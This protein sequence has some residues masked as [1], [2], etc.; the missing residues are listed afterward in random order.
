MV[1]LH[2]AALVQVIA[3]A[4][5]LISGTVRS[6][7]T[8]QALGFSIVTLLPQG[9]RQFTDSA[10]A[11][12]FEGSTSGTYILSVRQIGYAPLDTQIVVAGDS[13]TIVRVALRRL[14]IELPPVTVTAARCT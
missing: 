5:P 3:S 9:V 14:A 7:E 12:A 2:T 6:A 4:Q 10:G 11:F 13:P 8:G 1:L